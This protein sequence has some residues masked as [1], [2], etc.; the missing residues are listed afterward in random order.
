MVFGFDLLF[1]F[2]TGW[3][4]FVKR[5]REGFLSLPKLGSNPLRIISPVGCLS[6]VS[7]F[8]LIPHLCLSSRTIAIVELAQF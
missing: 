8:A 3:Y 6:W 4:I 7:C 2:I 5:R 1:S